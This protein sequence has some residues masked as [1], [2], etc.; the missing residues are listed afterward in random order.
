M[1]PILSK[2]GAQMSSL[3]GVR[4]IMNDVVET[5]RAGNGRDFINL[6][7]GNPVI[8]PQVEELWRDCNAQLLAS[9]E[10]GEVV[11]RYGSS[12]GYTPL[13]TAI[14][15]DFNQRYKLSL[16]PRNVLITPG[17]QSLFFYAVNAFG[18][19]SCFFMY[20]DNW[21]TVFH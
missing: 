5:L 18:G 21:F 4:A 15:D 9:Q 2:T 13:V 11:C 10:Y 7:V 14:I 17:S 3:T 19:Y 6:S 12:Q 1:N 20:S 8:L 16:N